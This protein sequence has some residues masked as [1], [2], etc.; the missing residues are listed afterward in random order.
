VGLDLVS[1]DLNKQIPSIPAAVVHA[2]WT[3]CHLLPAAMAPI[4][5]N[6]SSPQAL[7]AM[8]LRYPSLIASIASLLL[9]FIATK[10]NRILL[11]I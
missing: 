6:L 1:I 3:K 7:V 9:N 11:V 10:E 5:G 4:Q 2:P 8:N